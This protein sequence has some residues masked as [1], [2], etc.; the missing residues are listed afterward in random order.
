MSSKNHQ[1]IWYF[2]FWKTCKII[3]ILDAWPFLAPHVLE[4]CLKQDA[5]NPLAPKLSPNRTI[6]VPWRIQRLHFPQNGTLRVPWRP[7][8]LNFSEDGTFRVP[9]RLQHLNFSP[10][11][12]ASRAFASTAPKFPPRLDASRSLAPSENLKKHYLCRMGNI[13]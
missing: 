13:E 2:L 8:L 10:R 7:R 5:S 9:W 1:N 6:R 11:Q 12:D 4:S 3:K